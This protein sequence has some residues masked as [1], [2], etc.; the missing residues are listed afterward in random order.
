MSPIVLI[1]LAYVAGVIV[2]HCLQ[3]SL[4]LSFICFLFMA[5]V[6]LSACCGAGI[7]AGR[8]YWSFGRSD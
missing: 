5:A 3:P 1:T 8:C 2:G 7:A 6:F 4:A